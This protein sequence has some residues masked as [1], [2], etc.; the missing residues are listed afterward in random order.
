MKIDRLKEI[1][2]EIINFTNE[3]K[4]EIIMINDTSSSTEHI[5]HSS[6]F[7]RMKFVWNTLEI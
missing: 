1:L 5:Y 7:K 6:C 3:D 2:E 4:L